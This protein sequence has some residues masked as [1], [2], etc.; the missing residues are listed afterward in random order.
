M[1]S[2]A[3]TILKILL[4]VMLLAGESAEG[5]I[6]QDSSTLKLVRKDIDFIYNLQF[7]EARLLYDSIVTFYPGHPVAYL[8]SGMMIYWEHYPLLSTDPARSSF[9]D[10][11]KKCIS[12]AGY[13]GQ[14][15]NEAEYLLANLCAR[16]FLLMFYSDNN[17]VMDVIPLV[18]SSYKFLMRSFDYTNDCTDLYYFTGMY[19]Y[20]RDAYP[21][22]Y[23]VYKPLTLLFPRG[24]MAKGL[25]QI[26]IAANNAVVLR[27]EASFLL[28]YIY[29]NFENNYLKALR[30]S[31]SLHAHYPGNYQFSVCHLQNLLLLKRYDEAEYLINSITPDSSDVFCKAQLNIL[32]GIIQEKKY[33]NY[34]AAMNYYNNGIRDL[35]NYGDYGN[36][37]AAYGY[38]GL[39]RISEYLGKKH[40]GKMYRKEAIRLANFKKVDFD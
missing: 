36:E 8:L 16:G 27:A 25:H 31:S 19:N 7:Q 15:K 23:P 33:R 34:T 28:E 6:L 20:Y 32:A 5:Q 38:F 3:R 17:L 14:R 1:G 9:E 13:G 26:D 10:D 21:R 29:V 22:A 12:V 30:F 11:M 39:S 18:T 2:G 40:E 24:E 35:T 4:P 37:F